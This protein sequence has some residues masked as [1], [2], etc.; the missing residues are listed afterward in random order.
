MDQCWFAKQLNRETMRTFSLILIMISTTMLINSC[1]YDK[2]E[3]LYPGSANGPCTDTTGTTSYSQKVV[4]LLQ[5]YCY[6]CHSGNFP[7]GNI[8]MG[9]YAADKIIAQNGKLYGSI[10]HSPGFSPMPQIGGK[11]GSCQIAVIKK[12]IDGGDLNN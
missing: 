3:L 12:W 2:D 10:N 9:T 11:F 5:Q 6:S 1:Y 7:S 4:P 8:L